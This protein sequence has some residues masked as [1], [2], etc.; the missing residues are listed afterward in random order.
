MPVL[1]HLSIMFRFGHPVTA[2][3]A[4]SLFTFPFLYPTIVPLLAAIQRALT[5]QHHGLPK[6][7]ELRPLAQLPLYHTRPIRMFRI[8]HLP[9]V[10]I[11]VGNHPQPLHLSVPHYLQYNWRS[12]LQ[13][14]K[15][16]A[17]H[18]NGWRGSDDTAAFQPWPSLAGPATRHV[19]LTY[20]AGV[21]PVA[22]RRIIS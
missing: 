7:T 21:S 4:L 6:R 22:R 8:N 15:P 1:L 14:G 12:A 2:V 5:V 11:R 10:L 3:S 19:T 18:Q 20:F 13:K 17:Q 9:P 16:G